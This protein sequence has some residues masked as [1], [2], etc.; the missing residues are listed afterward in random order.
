MGRKGYLWDIILDGDD[1]E[2][3]KYTGKI[4]PPG[5]SSLERENAMKCKV[6][7]DKEGKIISVGYDDPEETEETPTLKSGPVVEENQTVVELDVPETLKMIPT[8]DF[9]KRLQSD[10]R[11]RIEKKTK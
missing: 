10:I 3:R 2:Y 11:A 6:T 8:E 1:E 5:G 9:V 7:L 4:P